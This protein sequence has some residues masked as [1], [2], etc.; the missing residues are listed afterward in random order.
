MGSST[1]GVPLE[2][3]EGET[4]ALSSTAGYLAVK[5][6]F[7]EVKAYCASAWRLALS[8][9]LVHCVFFDATDSSYTEN[10]Q[11]VTDRGTTNF[12]SL[13]A[14]Q[15]ADYVYLG[16][17]EPALGAYLDVP[18]NVNAT[19]ASLDVE[20]CSTAVAFG[21]TI[22]FTDVGGDSDGTQTGGDTTLGQSGVYT[23][24]LPTA[25]VRSTLGTYDAPTFSK[26]YWIRFK[27]SANLSANVDMTN[28]IPVYK[29]A[30]YGYMEA[31][32]EYQWS[33]SP[34][35]V[36]GFVLSVASGTPTLNVSWVQH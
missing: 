7:H 18:T 27:P 19:V 31:G 30:S 26:V 35:D 34:T 4:V 1:F 17:S 6:G 13:D 8:P 10:V 2:V 5:P 23:W 12:L 21:A 24:T 32:I 20:Y 25:W 33:F 29:N 36:G 3:L 14:M 16:F 11:S 22:A 15:T 9:A 28:I